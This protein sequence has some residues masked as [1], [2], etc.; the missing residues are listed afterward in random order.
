MVCHS[1]VPF[2]GVAGGF[3][4]T[5]MAT[6][7]APPHLPAASARLD[8]P[9][10][11]KSDP[12][13]S[14]VRGCGSLVIQIRTSQLHK[15]LPMQDQVEPLQTPLASLRGTLEKFQTVSALIA[16]QTRSW[17]P[18]SQPRTLVKPEPPRPFFPSNLPRRQ[19]VSS[20]K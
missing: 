13:I 4:E 5:S 8:R 3:L 1:L 16:S 12:F 20:G 14:K 15:L 11:P 9:N 17:P 18:T 6:T 19:L 7:M 10:M 2:S